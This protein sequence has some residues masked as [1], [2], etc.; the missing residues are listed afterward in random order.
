[1]SAP[2]RVDIG[3]FLIL[4]ASYA[5]FWHSR[6]WNSASRLMLTY[7]LVDRGTVSL[8]G[9]DKQTG[10]IAHFHGHYFS[11][12]LPGYSLLAA[13]PY[14][15]SK[16]LFRLPNHPLEREGFP[17]WQADYWVS[18]GTSGVVSAFTAV[19]LAGLAR[20]LG[21]GL[22]R[23]AL[24]AL[25]YG[26]A[27]PAYVYATMSYGHQ[28]SA[29]ALLA[30]FA[31]LW[32]IETRRT[33]LRMVTAGFLAAYASVIELQV[34]PVSAILG[35]YLLLQVIG[36][37]RKVSTLGDFTVGA[38][39]PSLLLLGY[40]QL[41][42]GSPW[43]MGYFHHAT[44]IFHQVHSAK[45]PLGLR[46]PDLSRLVPL[47]W[48]GYRGLF[49]YA[50]I[51]LL[52]I[53]GWCVLFGRKLYGMG[54]VSLTV[55]GAV[56]V[57]NLCY[58]EWTGGWSTGPRLLVPLIPF[59]MLPVAAF[60]S[61]GGP[62]PTRVATALSLLGVGLITLFQGAG[63]R[64]SEKIDD[65]LLQMVWPRWRGDAIP[66]FPGENRFDRTLFDVVH[67]GLFD[68]ISPSWSWLQFIPLIALQVLLV[69]GLMRSISRSPSDDEE[70]STKAGTTSQS[71]S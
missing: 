33:T 62:W 46:G 24:I 14:F 7:S 34:G 54:V 51:L 36:R 9:L 58:P 30:S 11:D 28:A 19:I 66:L 68:G 25:A 60:V 52:A 26:L 40:N 70:A 22:K 41:A 8:D 44:A 38:L 69:I 17:Y 56:F 10:D 3:V 45:N 48:G 29:F 63:G 5:F 53:P 61:L 37:K 59:A 23:S 4:L 42:F 6:D 39:I 31:L 18:L 50:P 49:F 13:T 16:N 67:P 64:V 21:C 27:T 1:M 32:R 43:D 71:L 57:V 55:C 47:L 65:P 12:K 2:R 20:D 15:V 35:I